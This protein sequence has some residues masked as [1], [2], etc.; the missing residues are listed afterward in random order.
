MGPIAH[1][2]VRPTDIFGWGLLSVIPDYFFFMTG[3]TVLVGPG[4]FS[5]S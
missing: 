5:D 4:L 2:D 1:L 3:S